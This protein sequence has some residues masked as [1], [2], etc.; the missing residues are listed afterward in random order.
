MATVTPGKVFTSNEIVTPAN[1]NLLGVPTVAV[2]DN[3]VTTAKIAADAVTTAK[4]LDANVTAAK[5]AA[6]AVTTAKLAANSVTAAKLGTTEQKQ[7][8]KAWVNFNGVATIFTGT[9]TQTG[10]TVTV[11]GNNYVAGGFTVGAT[12]FFNPS[13]GSGVVASGTVTTVTTTS[14]TFTVAN[15]A[16]TSGN[17][18]V[19]G[20]MMRAFYNISTITKNGTGDYT[21]NFTTPMADANYAVF[22][23]SDGPTNIQHV[24]PYIQS[25]TTSSVRIGFWASNNSGLRADPTLACVQIF[26][27]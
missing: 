4:L 8:C 16:S 21:L 6:D 3:E 15:S 25:I 1:L 27:N 23:S 7:I 11:A 24:N 22:I 2:A 20:Q 10:T 14:M 17:A 13:T 18:T 26:G 12:V 19:T 5:I 9:Y